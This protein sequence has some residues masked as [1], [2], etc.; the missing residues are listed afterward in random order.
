M[1]D[2]PVFIVTPEGVAASP[3]MLVV[4]TM[5]NPVNDNELHR[6]MRFERAQMGP[7]RLG[8]RIRTCEDFCKELFAKGS[9]FSVEPARPQ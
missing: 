7:G 1:K 6:V 9:A 8:A 4:V 3:D 5:W 2:T